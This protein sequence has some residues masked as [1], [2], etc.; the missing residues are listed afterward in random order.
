MLNVSIAG[1]RLG[2]S[3]QR[4]ACWHEE[5]TW[6]VA[7]AHL[8]KAQAFRRAG[9]PVP[10]GT[11]ATMLARLDQ[12]LATVPARRIVF[13]GDLLHAASGR[14]AAVLAAVADW[15]ARHPDL[16][17]VLVRGNHDAHAGDPPAD[18][19]VNVVD[20]PWCQGPFALCHHPQ[21]VAGHYALAGHTHPVVWL[22]GRGPGRLRLPCFH[23]GP[24]QG[25]LPA[26]GEFTGGHALPV[27]PGD[28]VFAVAEDRVRALP[29]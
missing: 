23:F 5:A 2:L 10:G 19:R 14:S 24:E 12:L 6:L 15:R 25:V 20:E 29:A 11:T 8:G 9:L 18:W 27:L 16:D 21:A 4:A 3:A 28:R 17:L 7:D 26:F 22:G 13:L 1:Q